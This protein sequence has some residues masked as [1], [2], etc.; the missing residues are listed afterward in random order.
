L[1]LRGLRNG[2][3]VLADGIVPGGVVIEDGRIA[4]IA[5]DAHLPRDGDMLDVGG[6]FVLPG[7]VDPEAHLGS[8][9]PLAEDLATESRAA[10]A[11]GVTTWNLQ[12]TAH[13][14]ATAFRDRPGPDDILP[15]PPLV[16]EFERVVDARSR[17][18]VALTPLLT[19]VEQTAEIPDLAR[20]KGITTYKLYLHMRLGHERLGAT[21]P[22]ARP[23]GFRPFDDALIFSAMREVAKL[24]SW[25]LLSLHCE[26]WEIARLL[27]AELQ[28]AGR[29]DTAA[30]SDRSP[31]YLESMH[32]RNYAYLA[33]QLGC[34]LHVQ[35]VSTVETL[36]ELARARA[37]GAEVYGQTAAHYLLLGPE[38]W[39]LNVPLRP[40]HHHEQLW[41]ALAAGG[42]NSVG[43]DHIG[44]RRGEQGRIMSR[45]E[46]DTG[47]VWRSTSG[48]A[49]R[50]EAH[51]P[52]LLS[53]GVNR[54]RLSLER[55]VEVACGNPARLWGLH[56]RKGIIQVGSDADL[57]VVDLGQRMVLSDELVISAAGWTV[58]AGTEV[59]GWPVL[60]ILR[61]EPVAEWSGSSCWV[62]EEPTGCYVTHRFDDECATMPRSV[63]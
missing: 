1:A 12:Q 32:V 43:S 3:L 57:V 60:T 50:V 54:R 31:A 45:A 8:V 16:D 44:P 52:L 9:G 19:A 63:R 51:L 46:M 17:C 58:Y 41:R 7:V 59:T 42:V 22:A 40:A 35:H 56:P 34:R 39:R 10:V 18:D 20:A 6:R 30:W 47:D 55:L 14:V 23:L 48:F 61:G 29:T 4:A 21:W 37:E 62:R 25:G 11:T 2:L 13:A 38:V 36:Q 24:G 5:D 28:A 33:R 15:F 26:N 49:S 27:E 53:E